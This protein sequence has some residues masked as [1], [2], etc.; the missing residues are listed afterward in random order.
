[1]N[2]TRVKIKHYDEGLQYLSNHVSYYASCVTETTSLLNDFQFL[3]PRRH[4]EDH[5]VSRPR[6]ARLGYP[7]VGQR[8]WRSR[9]RR[10]QFHC[11][12]AVSLG[13]GAV[14]GFIHQ[15]AGGGY[16][17]A[18]Y[19]TGSGGASDSQQMAPATQ[20]SPT[21]TSTPQ[22]QPALS[23]VLQQLGWRT[24][25]YLAVWPDP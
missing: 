9:V 1:M 4:G 5:A 16:D 23:T 8:D 13:A 10:N 20:M 3:Q 11:N 12:G 14:D 7:P 19:T 6:Q 17:Q 18:N 2:L 25:R 21:E 15:G 22:I 24:W